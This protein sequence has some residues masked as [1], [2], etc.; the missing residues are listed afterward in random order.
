[1]KKLG[2]VLLSIGVLACFVGATATHQQAKEPKMVRADEGVRVIASDSDFADFKTDLLD[3]EMEGKTVRLDAD[4]NYEITG[5]LSSEGAFRGTLDGNGHSIT[6]NVTA[7]AGSTTISLFRSIG[8]QG[9]VEN[10]T[11]EGAVSGGSYVAGI[12][13]RNYGLIRNCVNKATITGTGKFIGGIVGIQNKEGIENVHA[14]VINCENYGDVTSTNTVSESLGLGGIVG[15]SF[16]YAN[17]E[18]CSNFGAVI[19][20][21]QPFGVGGVLGVVKSG[22]SAS[23]DIYITNSYNGGN[24]KGDR[25]VGGIL[26]HIDSNNSKTVHISGCLNA[27]DITCTNASK[28][29]DGQLIGN[30]KNASSFVLES[31]AIIGSLTAGT[32]SNVGQVIG[33]P[34]SDT[35]TG[36]NI[37]TTAG[38][39][40][41]VKEVIKLVRQYDC[42]NDATYRAALMSA[43]DNL[44]SDE[45]TLLSSVT[46]WDKSE[47][48]DKDYISA[49]NY[50]I[51]NSPSSSRL[52]VLNK[53]NAL[54]YVVVALAFASLSG[55]VAFLIIRKKKTNL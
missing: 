47:S 6:I 23:G 10:L 4:I 45:E 53:N 22:S 35:Y 27:G 9:T 33:Y 2:G 54:L 21:T 51:G 28:G 49:A 24:V 41:S 13:C 55:L 38:V 20:Q 42:E 43:V 18:S 11:I 48:A 7:A 52:F 17:I 50:I 8:S 37:P 30:G 1:M 31:S 29:Y 46:Y 25:Y 14:R 39:S 3:D 16:G 5:P 44:T 34:K 26:G 12:T 19:A 36:V 32:T 40:N 15:Y